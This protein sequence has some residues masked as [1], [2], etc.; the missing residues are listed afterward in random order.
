MNLHCASV[1]EKHEQKFD[2]GD[3]IPTTIPAGDAKTEEYSGKIPN[4]VATQEHV[5]DANT[6]SIREE[7]SEITAA[8]EMTP[9]EDSDASF[10]EPTK[11]LLMIENAKLTAELEGKTVLIDELLDDKGFLREELRD[12]RDGRKDVTKIAERMLEA[13]ETMAL[14]AKLE[15]LPENQN[16]VQPYIRPVDGG[17][18]IRPDQDD[19][20]RV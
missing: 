10:E 9:E 14:G 19:E 11:A 5:G 18:D 20:Y 13:M 1:L 17:G 16:T 3:A 4:E 7:T 8:D 2:D 15:R 12:A 6:Q